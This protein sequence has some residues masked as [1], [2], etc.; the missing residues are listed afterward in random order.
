MRTGQGAGLAAS[1]VSAIDAFAA[2][3]EEACQYRAQVIP[4]NAVTIEEMAKRW[5]ESGHTAGQRLNEAVKAGRL[6]RG[7]RGKKLYYW[8]TEETTCAQV[9]ASKGKSKTK[10]STSY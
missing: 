1:T 5:G 4:K 6:M 3:I 9:A 7:K 2:A 8:P 10:I